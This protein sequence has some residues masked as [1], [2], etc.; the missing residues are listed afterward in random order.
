MHWGWNRKFLVCTFYRSV[1]ACKLVSADHSLRYIAC[2]WWECEIPSLIC[3]FYFSVVACKLVSADP[4][5]RYITC[6]WG[7]PHPVNNHWPW[8]CSGQ[9][10]APEHGTKRCQCHSEPG[11]S[12]PPSPPKHLWGPPFC[13]THPAVPPVP[14]SAPLS[15]NKV[16][17]TM[18][19]KTNNTKYIHTHTLTHIHVISLSHLWQYTNLY[20]S[21]STRAHV[22]VCVCVCVC[23]RACVRACVR[24]RACMCVCTRACAYVCVH[25]WMC[26]ND[27]WCKSCLV[28]Y[29]SVNQHMS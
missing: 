16:C 21:I 11:K 5:L 9:P 20:G 14:C 13:S 8:H 22:C 27:F 26:A 1:A 2:A 18:D 17:C 29:L 12:V 15:A 24:L 3:T 19:D 25:A 6:Y 10:Q 23:A 7:F 28:Q 4:Y